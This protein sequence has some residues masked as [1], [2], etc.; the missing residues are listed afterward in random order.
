MKHYLRKLFLWGVG[1]SI[2]ALLTTSTVY[3]QK[4]EA[5]NQEFSFPGLKLPFPPGPGRIIAGYG[6]P[7]HQ[8]R[9]SFYSL[10]ICTGEGCNESAID[11]KVLAPTTMRYVGSTHGY[12]MPAYSKDYHFFEI[13]DNGQSKLCMSLGHLRL[14]LEGG[15]IEQGQEVG[16]VVPYPPSRPHIHIGLWTVPSS[17]PCNG[18]S[19]DAIAFTGPYNLDGVNYPHG[20]D[21]SNGIDVIS[22]NSTYSSGSDSRV[23]FT[24][25]A[26]PIR[27]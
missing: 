11:Q 12:G 17:N 4:L 14:T 20:T 15:I 8:E 19:R 27:R 6:V 10:D 24:D 23:I 1:L 2:A 5:A 18:F 7:S 3:G 9:G 25:G 13:D 22:T 16:K 21:W 26:L